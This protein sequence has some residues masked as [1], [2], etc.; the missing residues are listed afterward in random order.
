M[1][2]D[3]RMEHMCQ[4]RVADFMLKLQ[5]TTKVSSSTCTSPDTA[6]LPVS[7]HVEMHVG[8]QA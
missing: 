4:E 3:G 6:L 1:L 5:R 7:E 2:A 8:P